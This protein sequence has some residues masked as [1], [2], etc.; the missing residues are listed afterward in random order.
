MPL[1][2]EPRRVRTIWLGIVGALLIAGGVSSVLHVDQTVGGVCLVHP[3]KYWTLTELRPGAIE[4]KAVDLLS[5]QTVE[6]RLYQFDRDAF[7]DLNLPRFASEY[8][9]RVPCEVGQVIASV[10]SS[11][12][13][14]ELAARSTV[15]AEARANLTALRAGAK[16][17]ELE[18][19][20]VAL[21]QAR[22]ARDAFQTRYERNRKLN[23][24]GLVSDD[25]WEEIAATQRLHDLDVGLAEAELAVLTSGARPED[26]EAAQALVTGLESELET[27]RSMFSAQEIRSPVSGW[28]R[29]GGPN[30]ALVSVTEL[31]TMVVEIL[32]PQRRADLLA[33]GHRIRAYVPGLTTGPVSGNVVRIDRRATHSDTGP[34]VRAYGVVINPGGSLEAD[35]EGR[36]RIYCGRTSALSLLWRDITRVMREELWPT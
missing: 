12:L 30:N 17:E 36:A 26:I 10:S 28:L 1:V 35:V 5:G 34:Y 15:L 2:P 33:E 27:L 7:L 21:Q 8:D 23:E 13:E 6:Y 32:I 11:A 22:A 9:S 18:R 25:I 3:A 29:L 20:R 4:S 24:S 19:A 16:P 14:R 31:D